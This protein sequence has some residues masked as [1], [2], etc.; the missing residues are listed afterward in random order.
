[1]KPNDIFKFFSK[2]GKKVWQS[3][4]TV[5]KSAYGLP[6][7]ATQLQAGQIYHAKVESA[8]H[9]G[10]TITCI[11]QDSSARVIEDCIWAAGLFSGIF[12]FKMNHAPARG[13]DVLVLFTGETNYIIGCFLDKFGEIKG[14]RRANATV[15]QKQG[16]I[17]GW[18]ETL[19]QTAM[20]SNKT[21]KTNPQFRGGDAPWDMVD[22]EVEITNL[23]GVGATFM[24]HISQLKAGDLAKVECG[25]ID[26]M[27]RI[28]SGNFKHHSAFGDCNISNDGGRLN[29][30]WDG[31]SADWEI[32]GKDDPNKPKLEQDS[33][34]ENAVKKPTHE[35]MIKTSDPKWRFSQFVGFLGDFINMFVT[36]P[37]VWKEGSNFEQDKRSGKAKVHIN[38]DGTFLV[39]SVGEIILERSPKITTPLE[40][41]PEH[42]KD[43]NKPGDELFDNLDTLRN[44]NFDASGG[45]ENV[46][47]TI[48]QIREYAKWLTNQHANAQ[49][50]RLEKDWKVPSEAES[51]DPEHYKCKHLDKTKAQDSTF[52]EKIKDVYATIKIAKDG[53]ILLLDA[54]DNSISLSETG[55]AIASHQDFLI[56]AAGS[57][58][59]MAGRDV[60]VVANHSVDVSATKGGLSLRGDSFIQQY[61]KLGG[62]SIETDQAPLGPIWEALDNPDAEQFDHTR[63]H[64]IVFKNTNG[65][66]RHEAGYD[67]GAKARSEMHLTAGGT[68][69]VSSVRFQVNDTMEVYAKSTSAEIQSQ[70]S[71]LFGHGA[72]PP[73]EEDG[74][75]YIRVDGFLVSEK[76]FSNFLVQYADNLRPMLCKDPSAVATPGGKFEPDTQ[77]CH[78]WH[79]ITTNKS[80]FDCKIEKT[81]AKKY[82]A[83]AGS[84]M[85]KYRYTDE[86]GVTLNKPYQSLCQQA[87][88]N[89]LENNDLNNQDYS[90]WNVIPA[91]T[92]PGRRTPWPVLDSY[93]RFWTSKRIWTPDSTDPKSYT[94]KAQGLNSASYNMKYIYQ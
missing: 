67:I 35:D 54:Y 32:F 51:E 71:S 46:H 21:L 70:D 43:G 12:G 41:L 76:L 68:V 1:M 57:I 30:R 69:G 85:F 83:N 19:F 58:N 44:W 34:T 5:D 73:S 56:E 72:P 63:I 42:H 33:S 91:S 52:P 81:N 48:Y 65:H 11:T 84:P 28:I 75:G 23:L 27:V 74:M 50:L 2:Y 92:I 88:M 66:I 16:T 80:E 38:E 62:I 29:A 59:L 24:R 13:T 86:Y 77:W 82:K 37:V 7:D 9:P 90:Q 31:T 53:S 79:V 89:N 20:R 78:P 18:F 64:G 87:L 25:I 15:D 40:K 36:D 49:F 60:N 6:A 14:M 26:D 4:H 94:N 39:S 3:E 8:I 55:V 17:K 47:Y 45:K 93:M 61:C 10:N 22:G